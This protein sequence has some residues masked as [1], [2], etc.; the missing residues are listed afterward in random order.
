MK[1]L[2]LSIISLFIASYAYSQTSRLEISKL[3]IFSPEDNSQAKVYINQDSRLNEIII[4]KAQSKKTF[5]VWRVQIYQGTG[6]NSRAEAG[7][8]EKNFK[9]K[10]GDVSTKQLYDPPYFKVHVGNFKTRLEAESFRKKI[11][12]EYKSLWVV[13]EVSEVN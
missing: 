11:Q 6:K 13:S 2:C 12:N 8:I 9:S 10:Y 4:G 5:T 7:F 1:Q 3:G